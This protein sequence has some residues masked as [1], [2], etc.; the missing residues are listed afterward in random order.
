MTQEITLSP[1]D[2]ALLNQGRAVKLGE[3]TIVISP[4]DLGTIRAILPMLISMKEILAERGVH[5]TD[6]L[7]QPVH[8]AEVLLDQLPELLGM[9]TG[10]RAADIRILPAGK[11][12]EIAAACV[13]VNLDSF[14]T[15]LKNSRALAAR[16]KQRMAG[17]TTGA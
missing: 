15:M 9:L 1:T 17:A 10:L 2:F 8:L 3:K 4:A 14:D 5:W 6:A 7:N 13:E 12:M 11:A 16:V